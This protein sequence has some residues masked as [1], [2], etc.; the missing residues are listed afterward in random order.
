[1][2]RSSLANLESEPRKEVGLLLCEHLSARPPAYLLDHML[3][4]VV[5][6][7]ISVLYLLSSWK[8]VILAA[9]NLPFLFF[10]AKQAR[11]YKQN[12]KPTS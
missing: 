3:S 8:R 2:L 11:V 9:A 4:E 12:C 10:R 1:M 6:V 5:P 7:E